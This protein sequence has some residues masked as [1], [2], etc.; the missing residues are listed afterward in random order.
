MKWRSLF[1]RKAGDH[2]PFSPEELDQ[3]VVRSAHVTHWPGANCFMVSIVMEAPL[4]SHR[5][6]ELFL[7]KR[8]R[9]G[10]EDSEHTFFLKEAT[11]Q[12]LTI[13]FCVSSAPGYLERFM[14]F[15]PLLLRSVLKPEVKLRIPAYTFSVFEVPKHDP[16]R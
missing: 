10:F 9:F 11:V 1:R 3:Y 2:P 14:R 16:A 5:M 8:L 6:K 13:T 7:A 4:Y 12:E 15:D